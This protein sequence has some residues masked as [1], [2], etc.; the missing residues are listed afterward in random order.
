MKR[1]VVVWAASLVLVAMATFAF[2]QTFAQGSRLP[3]P[4][5]LSGNDIGFRV[6]GT[7]IGGK[8]TGVFVVRFN[9]NWVE[10]GRS[11]SVRPATG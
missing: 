6:D 4:Q 5:M 8:P 2:A 11:V 10:L 9:G 3:E 7:D 1:L